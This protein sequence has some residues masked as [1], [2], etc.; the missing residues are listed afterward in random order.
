VVVAQ[1]MQ[2]APWVAAYVEGRGISSPAD[3]AGKTWGGTPGGPD[4]AFYEGYMKLNGYKLGKFVALDDTY[5][6]VLAGKIDVAP[7]PI[8]SYPALSI[9]ADKDGK[10]AAYFSL[11]EGKGESLDHYNWGLVASQK[12]LDENPDLV[13]AA[14]A[15]SVR[16]WGESMKDPD[17]AVAAM[18]TLNPQQDE[19]ST[20]QQLDVSLDLAKSKDVCEHGIGHSDAQMWD[21][22]VS[23]AMKYLS[24]KGQAPDPASLYTNDYLPDQ[25]VTPP[26]C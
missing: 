25:A 10:K 22:T 5:P 16:G 4:A 7:A 9:A 3:L 21:Q 19:E 20:K 23:L 6:A 1:I 11:T 12:M 15:A 26:D 14:V 17:A 2:H 18:K 8:T 24:I 13:R